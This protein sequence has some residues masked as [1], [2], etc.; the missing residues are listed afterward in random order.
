V[1]PSITEDL[2]S[3]PKPGPVRRSL[4][5][6][7][8]SVRS[9]RVTFDRDS[10]GHNPSRTV[11]HATLIPIGFSGLGSLDE[12]RSRNGIVTAERT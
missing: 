3:T 4:T 1:L 6:R 10:K 5:D 2:G 9:V 7:S 12:L 11:T 8:N